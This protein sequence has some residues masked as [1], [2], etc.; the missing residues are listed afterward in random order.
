M[1]TIKPTGERKLPG[2]NASGL[3]TNDSWRNPSAD[4]KGNTCP[5]P[6][7]AKGPGDLVADVTTSECERLGFHRDTPDPA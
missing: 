6:G 3:D 5:G 4:I 1:D 7:V 2:T